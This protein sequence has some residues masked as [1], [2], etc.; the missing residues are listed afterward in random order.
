MAE[1]IDNLISEA[2]DALKEEKFADATEYVEQA[3]E[4]VSHEKDNYMRTLSKKDESKEEI[5]AQWYSQC[6]FI[7]FKVSPKQVCDIIIQQ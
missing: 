6:A 3:L 4:K 2:D 7:F 1:A 5:I